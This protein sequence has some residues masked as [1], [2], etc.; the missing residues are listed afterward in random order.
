MPRGYG[1]LARA[2]PSFAPGAAPALR[3]AYVD[4][5][6]RASVVNR[7]QPLCSTIAALVQPGCP[8]N[9]Q[10]LSSVCP[11]DSD[12]APVSR[13]TRERR[14]R[15][16]SSGVF[17]ARRPHRTIRTSQGARKSAPILDFDA[18]TLLA[19]VVQIARNSAARMALHAGILP[20]R[21][22]TGRGS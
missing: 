13:P 19:Q 12:P 16:R 8:V 4:R 21:P 10:S 1:A 14:H 3:G 11:V 9:V 15:G 18:S 5:R 22:L 7:V 2:T 6:R 17:N 20:A